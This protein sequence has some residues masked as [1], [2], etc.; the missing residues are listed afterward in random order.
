LRPHP[1]F[2][3][4]CILRAWPGNVRELRKEVFHAA[5]RARDEGAERVR[6]DHL[7]EHAGAPIPSVHDSSRPPGL[8]GDD[9]LRR[10]YV[11]WSQKLS[12]D[13]IQRALEEHEGNVSR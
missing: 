4:A 9:H 3:E 1:R 11:K 7:G 10:P 12:K 2:V 5:V 13:A 6:A 8:G